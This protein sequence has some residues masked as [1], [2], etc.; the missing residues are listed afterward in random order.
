M[1]FPCVFRELN[2]GSAAP[3]TQASLV[4]FVLPLVSILVIA[5]GYAHQSKLET[6]KILSYPILFYVYGIQSRNGGYPIISHKEWRKLPVC[7]MC[8][9][10]LST[11]KYNYSDIFMMESDGHFFSL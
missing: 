3:F 6:V 7:L 4:D 11:H 1:S 10:L 5:H 8:T 9:Q 2:H